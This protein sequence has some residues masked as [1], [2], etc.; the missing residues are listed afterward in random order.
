MIL[1][2]DINGFNGYAQ[3]KNL[4]YFLFIIKINK[5][6]VKDKL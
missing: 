2:L 4:Q 1:I 6:I 3:C 5:F